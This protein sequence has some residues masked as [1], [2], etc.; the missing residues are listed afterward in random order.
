MERG[1]LTRAGQAAM[2]RLEDIGADIW[3]TDRQG[4]VRV[5]VKGED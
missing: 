1:W 4:T 5:T 3:R 2:E